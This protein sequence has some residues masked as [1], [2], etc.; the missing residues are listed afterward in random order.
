MCY[1]IQNALVWLVYGVHGKKNN[2]KNPVILTVN[3]TPAPAKV[4]RERGQVGGELAHLHEAAALLRMQQT[5]P[6]LV[7]SVRH[8]QHVESQCFGHGQQHSQQPDESHLS[9]LPHGDAHPLHS[10]PRRHRVVAAIGSNI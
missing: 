7:A 3:G 10:A 2:K 6:Q 1:I 5:H 9:C 4:D 8:L